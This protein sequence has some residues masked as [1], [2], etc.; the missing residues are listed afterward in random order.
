MRDTIR[1]CVTG[2]GGVGEQII[3]TLRLADTPYYILGTDIST[4]TVFSLVDSI[5]LVPLAT[6]PNYFEVI[7][8]LC[9]EH[10]IQVLLPGSEPELLVLGKN[11]DLFVQAGILVIASP[12]SVLNLC[13][14]K[15]AL[16]EFMT[17]KNMHPIWYRR[18]S[19]IEALQHVPN[20]PLI[21]KP[22]MGSG[23]SVDAFIV[24]DRD[25][26]VLFAT[27]LLKKYPEFIAQEYVGTEEDEYTVGI[28]AD[29]DGVIINSIALHR[30]L[31]PALSCR[32]RTPNRTGRAELGEYLVIS[33]GFSQGRIGAFPEITRQ[34][35]HIVN[36]L[37]ACG[38]TNLQCRLVKG[39][40][41]LFEIN[42]RFSGTSAMRAMAGLNEADLLI[43]YHILNENIS[44]HFP[45]QNLT[46]LRQVQEI[47]AN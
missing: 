38:P 15:C 41:A 21:F 2:I 35:E 8:N 33:S 24:Q 22:S 30:T 1:V 12:Q 26:A 4:S 39:K 43:R 7:L 17:A 18:I 9:I 20:W 25:E 19:T 28:L 10:K 34:C 47:I 6:A 45:V 36:A 27:Y 40:I 29:M 44:R 11:R 3:K 37:G 5:A 14:D 23:G 42:P 16:F 31:R 13:L 32:L 46:I